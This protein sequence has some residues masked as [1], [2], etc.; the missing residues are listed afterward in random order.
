MALFFPADK[1]MK[2]LFVIGVSEFLLNAS[3]VQVLLDSL[4]K[5]W[6]HCSI[7]TM[8]LSIHSRKGIRENL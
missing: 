6:L 3:D 7:I 2:L 5:G 4:F 8:P 1:V